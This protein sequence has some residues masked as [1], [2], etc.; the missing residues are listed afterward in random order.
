MGCSLSPAPLLWCWL[1]LKAFAVPLGVIAISTAH[2]NSVFLG[3][4][5]TPV[6]VPKLLQSSPSGT[7]GQ[8]PGDAPDA[9]SIQAPQETPQFNSSGW[10]NWDLGSCRKCSSAP[11]GLWLIPEQCLHIT[12]CT[13]CTALSNATIGETAKRQYVHPVPSYFLPSLCL[14]LIISPQAL[15]VCFDLFCFALILLRSFLLSFQFWVKY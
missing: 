5:Q 8:E 11:E 14:S 7:Q 12:T 2:K 15:C 6:W 4:G 10:L 3:P 1:E 13:F 9:F